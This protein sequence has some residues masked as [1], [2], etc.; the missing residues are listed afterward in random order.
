MATSHDTPAAFHGHDEASVS[1][2]YEALIA[3]WNSSSAE[4]FAAP[5]SREGAV[6][7]FDGS[8]NHGRDT[9]RTE[10]QAIFDDHQPATFVTKVRSIDL[11]G[12][13]A[14]MLRAIVGMVL[15]GESDLEPER[16]A[17]QTVVAVKEDGDWR[18][19]LFQN[20]PAR[21]DGRPELVEQF[22][23][24]LREAAGLN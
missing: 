7:G 12:S 17:H 16:N 6:I 24:E 15:P 18:I 11:L 1:A 22:T 20:T 9:I 5:F 14:A 23:E 8:E 21:F 4:G 3:G 13:D 19:A 2:L 10:M